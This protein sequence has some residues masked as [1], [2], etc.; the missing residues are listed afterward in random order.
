MEIG[1]RSRHV[2]I[3]KTQARTSKG[4]RVTHLSEVRVRFTISASAS[5]CAPASSTVLPTRLHVG[6][7]LRQGGKTRKARSG[8]HQSLVRPVLTLS[9]A[10]SAVISSQPSAPLIKLKKGQLKTTSQER[11]EKTGLHAQGSSNPLQR[12]QSR[13]G[14]Q[15]IG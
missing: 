8:P 9:M 14:F 12:C 2:N 5:A 1:E 13:V 6:E 10:A 3:H 15:C 11:S 4:S 7:S